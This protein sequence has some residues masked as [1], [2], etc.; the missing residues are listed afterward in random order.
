[1]NRLRLRAYGWLVGCT[2][3]GV[4]VGVGVGRAW[5]EHE[6]THA[7]FDGDHESRERM[8]QEALSR[9]LDLDEIQRRAVAEIMT[10][11]RSARHQAMRRV[12]SECGKELTDVQERIDTA[13]LAQLKPEQQQRFREW[14]ERRK[15][16]WHGE[17]EAPERQ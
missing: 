11:H 10:E 7:L 14:S 5:A 13:I 15:R 4:L 16:R 8:F 3:L 17:A 6:A 1:M 2:L 9:E 12:F